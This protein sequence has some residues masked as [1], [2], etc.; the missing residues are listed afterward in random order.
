MDVNLDSNYA[1][2]DFLTITSYEEPYV[3]LD[4]R[5]YEKR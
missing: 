1:Y 2:F 5:L 3:L 4:I